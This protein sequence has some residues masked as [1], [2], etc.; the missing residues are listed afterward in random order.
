MDFLILVVSIIT[1]VM[2]AIFLVEDIMETIN[3]KKK[4][5]EKP[6]FRTIAY[7]FISVVS[8]FYFNA[9]IASTLGLRDLLLA[10]TACG[11]GLRSFREGKRLIK[12]ISKN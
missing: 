10:I 8:I 7:G 9:L 2:L 11:F 4:K 3:P 5:K 12:T 6:L 1:V